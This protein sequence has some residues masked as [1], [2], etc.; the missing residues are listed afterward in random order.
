MFLFSHCSTVSTNT[1]PDEIDPN[2]GQHFLIS[3]PAVLHAISI[4]Q[5]KALT[6][7]PSDPALRKAPLW[8]SYAFPP[9]RFCPFRVHWQRWPEIWIS[10]P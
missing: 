10:G 3:Q 2:I 9:V 1:F 5:A 8:F 6:I 4:F 7:A